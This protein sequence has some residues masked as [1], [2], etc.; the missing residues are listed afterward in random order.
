MTDILPVPSFSAFY[1]PSSNTYKKYRIKVSGLVYPGKCLLALIT[2][3][4]LPILSL[5]FQ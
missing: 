2:K 1:I 4:G 5:P 3:H